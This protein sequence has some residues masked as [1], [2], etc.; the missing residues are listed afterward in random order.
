MKSKSEKA[1]WELP[2]VGGRRDVPEEIASV[3]QTESTWF[4]GFDESFF[5]NRGATTRYI[6]GWPLAVAYGIYYV[7]KKRPM[8]TGDISPKKAFSAICRGIRENRIGKQAGMK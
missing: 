4:K 3:A 5:Y 8:Y 2:G 6:L 1:E 7:I